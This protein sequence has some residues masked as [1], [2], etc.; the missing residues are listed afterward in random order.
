M[1]ADVANTPERV[2]AFVQCFNAH[3]TQALIANLHTQVSMIEVDGTAFPITVNAG[4]APG[5]CY[6]CDP[7]TGYADYALDET[8]NFDGSAV[9]RGLSRG[10]I[11][12]ASP[13]VR[14]AGLDRVVHVNNW[15]FSTNPVPAL[16]R[17]TLDQMA[18][19]LSEAH[20]GKIIAIRSLNTVADRGT[21]KAARAAGFRLLA[22]RQVYIFDQRAGVSANM[23]RD[24]KLLRETGLR[25]VGTDQFGGDDFE[26]A[27]RLYAMLYLEKYTPL[28]P[29]YTGLYLREMHARGLIELEGL[30]EADGVLVA[31]TGLFANGGTLTQPIVGYDTSQPLAAGLYRMIMALGQ[32]RAIERGL[33]FNM[34]A[35]AASFKRLRRARP[36][37]EYTAIYDCHLP[38]RQRMAIG[39]VAGILARVGVPLL[40]R[41]EL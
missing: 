10:L 22:A 41:F 6:I 21:L 7:V 23:R 20:P 3:P 12:G 8:R 18:G 39:T 34:S 14:A 1:A 40:Q 37:I 11:R 33:L 24:A 19:R 26:R 31:V 35:G 13:L 9:V 17:T 16:D 29:Q 5:N 15:L 25:R 36:A 32:A 38:L 30:R 28:N 4:R 27:A 2:R